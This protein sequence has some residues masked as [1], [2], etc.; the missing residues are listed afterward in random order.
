MLV[1][2]AA[3]TIGV[4]LRR[5]LPALGWRLRLLDTAQP[6]PAAAGEE[7]VNADIRNGAA[8]EAAMTGI[9]AVVHL[10]AYPSPA[11]PFADVLE[12]NIAGTYEVFDAARRAGVPRIVF[13]SSNHAVGF[14][15]RAELVGVDVPPRPDSYYGVSKVFGEALGR[16]YAD[17]YGMRVAALRIGSCQDRPVTRRHLSTWLSPGDMVRLAAACLAA[18]DL[19]YA[20]V[21]GISANS[22]RWWDLGPGRALGYEPV[23]DA[24]AYAAEVL[25]GAPPANPDDP[26]ERYVGG[27]F[28][29]PDYDAR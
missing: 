21:Y 20:V 19:T 9:E 2:G 6:G 25:A 17:R 14:T 22:R 10:A 4:M 29:G 1:T 27:E 23:D 24:E 8:V 5:G 7:I 12:V 15:P 26:E 28:A 3:G 13:A 11:T 18:P 16:L